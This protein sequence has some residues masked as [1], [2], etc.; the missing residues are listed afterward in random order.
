MNVKWVVL[1]IDLLKPQ[2]P[3]VTIRLPALYGTPNLAIEFE[4]IRR[5]NQVRYLK[6]VAFLRHRTAEPVKL[7]FTEY[8]AAHTYKDV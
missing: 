5:D 2:K 4:E 6:T 3:E 8:P 7:A 1:T